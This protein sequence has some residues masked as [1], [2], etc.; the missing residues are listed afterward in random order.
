M[1]KW[2]KIEL[3]RKSSNGGISEQLEDLDFGDNICLLS[4]AFP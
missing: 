1:R 2:E 4:H 3:K